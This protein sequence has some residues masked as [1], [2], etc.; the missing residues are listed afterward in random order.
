MVDIAIELNVHL[1]W[2][3]TKDGALRLLV[4]SQDVFPLMQMIHNSAH[5]W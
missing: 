4:Y 1:F 5:S 2:V 3:H